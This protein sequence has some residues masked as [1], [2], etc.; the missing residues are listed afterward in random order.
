MKFI[1]LHE[2]LYIYLTDPKLLGY[3][4]GYTPLAFDV[5]SDDRHA[6]IPSYKKSETIAVVSA[7]FPLDFKDKNKVVPLPFEFFE[8]VA[9]WHAA[10]VNKH[11]DLLLVTDKKHLHEAERSKKIGLILHTEGL[12]N[13]TEPKCIRDLKKLNYKSISL[14]WNAENELCSTCESLVD[15]G[16]KPKGYEIVKAIIENGLILDLTH[17]SFKTQEDILNKFDY[18]KVMFSHCGIWNVYNFSQNIKLSVLEEIAKRK[19]VVGLTFLDYMVAG[20]E[21]G[22]INEFL[23]HIENSKEFSEALG[24]GTDFFGFKFNRGLTEIP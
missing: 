21:K 17:S 6:D 10:L 22:T 7:A 19:G 13:I 1:D 14:S 3:P 15:E 5:Q 12:G 2:D 8:Q 4:D 18:T 16:L 24:I 11:S 23:K 20:K 9:D